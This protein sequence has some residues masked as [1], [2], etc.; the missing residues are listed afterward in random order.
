MFYY[1]CNTCNSF[2]DK[3]SSSANTASS[4]KAKTG[5]F[6]HVVMALVPAAQNAQ[7]PPLNGCWGLRGTP[8]V[9]GCPL[10]LS[11]GAPFV[12][13]I[14]WGQTYQGMSQNFISLTKNCSH[15]EIFLNTYVDLTKL[16]DDVFQ[17]HMSIKM[18]FL[19]S[20]T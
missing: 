9:A 15:S 1:H 11:C 3:R 10:D 4:F 7:C 19:Q 18:T 5:A 8:K 14:S 12:V 13:K 16:S 6:S 2:S 20:F 17:L